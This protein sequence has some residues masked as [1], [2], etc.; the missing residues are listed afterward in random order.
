MYR[1]IGRQGSLHSKAAINLL[2]MIPAAHSTVMRPGKRK[3]ILQHT[4]TLFRCS[5]ISPWI[6][7][8]VRIHFTAP[9]CESNRRATGN[10]L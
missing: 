9:V 10:V 5:T 3:V 8:E 6:R 1:D 2:Y 4:Y 7:R